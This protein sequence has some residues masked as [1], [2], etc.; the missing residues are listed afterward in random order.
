MKPRTLEDA[1]YAVLSE[2]K[3]FNA[4]NTAPAMTKTLIDRIQDEM[5]DADVTEV[6]LAAIHDIIFDD[7]KN[8]PSADTIKLQK[9]LYK[10]VLDWKKRDGN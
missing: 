8:T 3:K 6:I 5:S 7:N 1:A 9:N 2:S 4:K 10:T